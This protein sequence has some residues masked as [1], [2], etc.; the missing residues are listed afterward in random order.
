MMNEARNGL[1]IVHL[2]NWIIMGAVVCLS[3]HAFV[4]NSRNQN[5]YLAVCSRRVLFEF[6]LRYMYLCCTI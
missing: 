3:S 1:E 4:V 6:R 2:Q 5:L